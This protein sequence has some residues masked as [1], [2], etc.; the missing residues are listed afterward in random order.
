M[1]VKSDLLGLLPEKN[2]KEVFENK[3]LS[4]NLNIKSMHKVGSLRN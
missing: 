2:K 4:E 3:A 1:S